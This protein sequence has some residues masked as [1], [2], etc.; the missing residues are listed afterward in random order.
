M[1]VF[2][3]SATSM[4]GRPRDRH[5]RP[6][7]APVQF[8]Q[9]SVR[10][11]PA[12]TGLRRGELIGLRWRHVDWLI[13]RK[14]RVLINTVDGKDGT[15][16]S[17]KGRTVPLPD[18]LVKLLDAHSKATKWSRD[19]DRVFAHPI[20]GRALDASKISKRFKAAAM[21]AGVGEFR[22]HSL[23][24]LRHTF[25]VYMAKNPK[26][27]LVELQAWM[28]HASIKTTMR[29]AQFQPEPQPQNG[30]RKPS[31]TFP[32]PSLILRRPRLSRSSPN[33]RERCLSDSNRL[34]IQ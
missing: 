13:G 2:D 14:I 32:Q 15:P 21:R 10:T 12:M 24:L 27:N 20:T 26:V 23:R 11:T 31:R 6:D 9:G 34:L 29:Y 7:L 33:G 18:S 8:G 25:A 3:G 4:G 19:D 22:F 5:H 16:K 30:Q 17:G 28:G 1:G